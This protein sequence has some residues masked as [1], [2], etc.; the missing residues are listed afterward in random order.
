MPDKIAN[1]LRL[2]SARAIL[3][4][5]SS[6]RIRA[7]VPE[8]R[9]KLL[10]H[11]RRLSPESAYFRFMAHKKRL[12]DADLDRFTILDY[13]R[14]FG[15]AA[16]R[17][18]HNDERVIGVG[19]YAALGGEHPES[20]EVAF[21]VDDEHQGRGVGTLLL[22]HLG[23]IAHANGISRLE[24]D[25]LSTNTRMLEVFA[26]SG[27]VVSQSTEAGVVR[28]W[29]AIEET[30]Q[31]LSKSLYREKLAAA[32]SISRLLNPKSV[33]IVG[34]SRE[35]TKIGGAILANL[36]RSF[37]G[38]IY[39]INPQA[40]EVQG[41]KAFSNLNA[42]GKPVD[43][44]VICVSAEA[45][46]DAVKQCAAIGVH[47]V[48][49]ITSGFSEVSAEGRAVQNRIVELVRSS[50]MR[51]VGPNCMG[52]INTDP[53]VGLNATFAPIMPREGNIGMLS[54]SGALGIAILDQ[55][56]VRNIGLS[57][58][59]SAGNKADVS[60]NDMI[61]YWADDPRTKAIVLYLESFGNPHKFARLAPVVA[62][63]KPI[64]AVKSGRSAA[65]RRAAMSHS[66]SLA[67]LDVAVEALFEQTGVIRTNTLEELFDLVAL[68]SMQPVPAGP[69]V[70]VV[71]NAGGPAILLADACEARGLRLPE[72]APATV[73]ELRS[74]LTVRAGFS[75]PVDMTASAG[76]HDFERTMA[77][78]GTDPN[79]DSVV[80]IYIPPMVTE[81][82]EIAR[83][84]ARGA[85]AV[86]AGKPV[87]CVFMSSLGHPA[88]LSTGP[89]G[90]L[91]CYSFPENAAIALEAANRYGR[92]RNRPR[93]ATLKLEQ[94]AE[95]AIRTVV[96]RVMGGAEAPRWL[97]PRELSAV[98][99][100]AGIDVA[101]A[102]QS[103]VEDAPMVAERI[104]YPLVAKVVS[105]DVIH[106]SD[107]GGIIMGLHSA[108][109]VEEAVG[110]LK[111]RMD[112]LDKR[113][114]GIL[115]QREVTEGIEALVGVTTDPTFGPL[116]VCGLGGVT[117]ELVKDVAFRLHPVTD[118]DA[119]EMVATLR[120]SPLLDG[121][122]G[123]PA[124]DRSALIS[125]VRKISALVE[126]VPEI[127]ELDLNPVKV[128]A[129]GK[130]AIVID[131]RMS[132][133]PMRR[134]L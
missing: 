126:I 79:V 113:L 23:R 63:H 116:V 104:G 119:A 75:N 50:G 128:L 24:A 39:P 78:V 76:P 58:F 21:A 81:P 33:A 86:P 106:K 45:V 103:T 131:A 15:L 6:V 31:F 22:E 95:D 60:G 100:A 40:L 51:M 9:E 134:L 66:A 73:A 80:V 74:F 108:G 129:P 52:I 65:G 42:V 61:A 72:L 5:G 2:Y 122:R 107:V 25:V 3:A 124:G 114:E 29:F 64:V 88:E 109:E 54:Q 8:D 1:D 59:I 13:A 133:A 4:D 97:A 69:R 120:S 110:R 41:L 30:E 17:L 125:I 47:G 62:R 132:L 112:D 32:A 84:I 46:E 87:A 57:S 43:L 117:V 77:A 123:A 91:P 56:R 18:E 67:S 70:G 85:A 92:W 68:L 11:F 16:T 111:S 28:V 20:A 94:A 99:A 71:T 7:I 44:A 115:L 27:F 53:A 102:E 121:Y 55:A 105:P 37:T 127:I 36:K 118:T 26:R 83:G 10:D 34:A 12:T 49:V 93:G 98:L 101:I 48:V 90:P 38:H 14:N 130:G 19:L 89:R 96:D 82:V 35:T